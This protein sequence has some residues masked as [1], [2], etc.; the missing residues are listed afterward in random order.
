MKYIV[1]E[2]HYSY[3]VVLDENGK[4]LS[5]ANLNYEVGQTVTSVIQ[6]NE[7]KTEN[8]KNKYKW[9]RAAASMVAC[10]VMVVAIIL[11]NV[12]PKPYG[13]VYMTIN[14][15][16][17]IDVDEN[18]VVV[19]ISAINEDGKTFLEKY[20]HKNKKLDVVMDELIDRAIEME[21]LQIGG[22]VTLTFDADNNEW[23]LN[24]SDE[25]DVHLHEYFD[26]KISIDIVIT[27]KKNDDDTDYMDSDYEDMENVIT[28][29][30]GAKP[31]VSPPDSD[32]VA[33]TTPN[34][35]KEDSEYDEPN[36]EEALNPDINTGD[37]NYD[38][39]DYDLDEDKDDE[40]YSD[41]EHGDLS[42]YDEAETEGDTD[43]LEEEAEGENDYSERD[44]K[45]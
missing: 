14:P 20:N 11:L 1:M 17:C 18:D 25:M 7:Y 41:Y 5:V 32:S 6:I 2:C 3:A 24:K 23:I 38:D 26:Q 28:D 22:R 43:S 13:K 39:S 33:T 36:S 30:S 10:I 44:I 37:S 21:Y 31:E 27:N 15:E 45:K 35:N 16:V 29:G 19:G 4:F 8:N 34:I 12:N 40:S 9:V 42:N